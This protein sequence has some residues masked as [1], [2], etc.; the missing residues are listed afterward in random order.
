MRSQTDP[1][2][3]GDLDPSLT[4]ARLS[5][6][7]L[8]VQ[9]LQVL[10]ILGTSHILDFLV[11]RTPGYA[12]SRLPALAH[13]APDPGEGAALAASQ[14]GGALWDVVVPATLEEL[15]FRG[16]LF[17]AVRRCL[18]TRPAIFATAALFGCAH[19]DLHHGV[20]AALLGLQL[21]A[22]R[23]AFGLP[24]AIV[25]HVANNAAASIASA[26]GLETTWSGLALAL[27]LSGS[28]SAVLVQ[29]LMPEPP[30]G[31]AAQSEREGRALREGRAFP[32]RR[33]L[34]T[35]PEARAG[36]EPPLQCDARSDE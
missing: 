20:V 32:D 25:A 12:A 29:A 4:A 2:V 27:L 34:E 7:N 33:L 21:G 16:L 26:I 18:G 36:D 13:R 17:E 6:A 31:L 1:R 35:E 9:A 19:L 24:L 30:Q 10:G 22:L 3:A 14:T 5:S 28:A 23:A 8:A 11:R 15:L